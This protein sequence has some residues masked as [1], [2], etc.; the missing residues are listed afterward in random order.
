MFAAVTL[1]G[2]RGILFGMRTFVMGLD[3]HWSISEARLVVKGPAL[4]C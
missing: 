2:Q 3:L 4:T 1:R